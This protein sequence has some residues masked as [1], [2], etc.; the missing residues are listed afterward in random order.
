MH[1]A[2]SSCSETDNSALKNLV[3][4]D[5]QNEIATV[6]LSLFPSL[7]EWITARTSH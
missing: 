6:Y 3:C 1:P 4:F 7:P 2:V 5:K